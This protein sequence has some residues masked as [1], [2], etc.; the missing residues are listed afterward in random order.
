MLQSPYIMLTPHAFPNIVHYYSPLDSEAGHSGLLGENIS[1]NTLD[2]GL[3]RRLGVE[4]LRV[5][6]IVDIVTNTDEFPF[7]VATCEKDHSDA[8]NVVVWD[9]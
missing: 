3:G 9:A 4:L 1:S 5:V 6:L 8:Q 2:D 7:V